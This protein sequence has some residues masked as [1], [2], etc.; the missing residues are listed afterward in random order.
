VAFGGAGGEQQQGVGA[1]EVRADAFPS[2]D[3]G[4]IGV[5]VLVQAA[6][7]ASQAGGGPVVLLRGAGCGGEAFGGVGQARDDGEL[8]AGGPGVRLG[9][10]AGEVS[11]RA[12]DERGRVGK[13]AGVNGGVDG[14]AG[15]EER[16]RSKTQLVAA[17][18]D[19]RDLERARAKRRSS[20]GRRA[21][22]GRARRR[23]RPESSIRSGSG[24]PAATVPHPGGVPQPSVQVAGQ[25]QRRDLHAG[26]DV[27]VAAEQVV[28]REQAGRG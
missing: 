27:R 20:A 15:V 4:G 5:Q 28:R 3:G 9:P 6:G 23:P 8:G 11:E 21:T 2:A 17:V 12:V 26:R 7:G 16:D 25:D 14:D 13:L 1:F 24:R 10:G 18:G 22:G 19:A